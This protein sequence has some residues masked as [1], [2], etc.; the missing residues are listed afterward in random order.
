MAN[1]FSFFTFP[2]GKEKVLLSSLYLLLLFTF[3]MII[4]SCQKKNET[5]FKA[6]T[7]DK[8]NV[9]FAN[10]ITEND[11]FNILALEYVYNGGGVAAGDFNNDGLQDLYFTGNMVSNKLYLNKGDMEF[12]DVTDLAGVRG[13]GNWSSGVAV[14]DINN[15]G[16]LDLYVCSTV[17]SD[18]LRRTN[19]LF[20]NQGPNQDGVPT[21]TE[22]ARSYGIADAGYS[23]NAA[24][25]DFDLD[26]D[27]DLYVLTNQMSKHLPTSYKN[28]KIDGSALNNDRLYRNNGDNTFT[29]ITNEAGILIEGYGL[30]LAISDINQDGWPDVY[31]TNDFI[32]EDLLYINNGDGT[33]TN[34][35][36]DYMKHTSASAMGNDVVDINNDGLP[37]ILA[38]DMLPAPNMRK[39]TML[40][41]NNYATY[42]NNEKFNLQHQYIRNTF[43]LNNGTGPKGHPTFSEIGMLAGIHQTDWSWAPLVA[44]FDNDGL[45]DLIITNGFPR[46]VTDHDFIH[47]R[48]GP[49]GNIASIEMLVDLIPVV[50]IS[51][52]GFRNNGDLT[53]SDKTKEWGLNIPSFSNGAVYVDLDNDGDLEVVVNTIN[54]PALVYENK[55]YD[56]KNQDQQSHHLRIKLEGEKFN[57]SGFGTKVSIHYGQGKK[58]FYE[59]SPSRGYLSSVEAVG[60][61][62]LGSFGQIDSLQVFW[63][64]GSYQL[65]RNVSSN[66]QLTVKQSDAKERT[67]PFLGENSNTGKNKMLF[68]EVA[69]SYGIQ[70]R[71]QET[72]KIDFDIQRTLP[73]KYSQS[74]PG[75]A[76]GDVDGNGL[77]DFFVGGAAGKSAALFLQTSEGFSRADSSYLNLVQAKAAEDMGSIFFDADGDGD[78]DLYVVSGSYEFEQEAPELQDRLYLNN[79]QGLFTLDPTALPK[80][81]SSGAPVKAADFDQDGDLDLFVGGRIVSGKYPLPS[82]SYILRNQ[83]GQFMDVTAELCPELKRF[84][85]ISDALW[86]DFNNDGKI[87]LVI[88]AEWQ[89]L[90]FFK[91]VAGTLI[92]VTPSSGTAHLKGW[93]NSLSSGD[94]DGD[95]DIDYVAGNLGLNTHYKASEEQPLAVYAKDFDEDGRFDAVL[96]CYWKAED[97]QMKSYPMHTRDDLIVQML[98]T[99]RHFPKY[100]EYGGATIEQVLS[101]EDLEGALILKANHFATTYFENLGNGKFK[102]TPL[103]IQ[104]QFAPVFGMMSKDFDGDEKKDILLVGNNYG[105]EVFTG[106]HDASIGLFLKGDGKGGFK[107]K[108]VANSGFF[109][110]GDAKGMAFLYDKNGKALL[111]VS[112]NQDSLKLFTNAGLVPFSSNG[113]L[114]TLE[115]MDAWAEIHYQSGKKEK[116]EFYY[117]SSYL[118]Q[119][120][121]KLRLSA[122]VKGVTIYDFKGKSRKISF[123]Q[124]KELTGVSK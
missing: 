121:R 41:A 21:F 69:I 91:N 34:Q 88:A 22:S 38:M 20:I 100:K 55:L 42:T 61:F 48:S 95:G 31:V 104:A 70:Y 120:S 114:L 18:S 111:L 87:D 23:T 8:T 68:Q 45:R 49:A 103:P 119:S 65:L 25:F 13:K 74:G 27:L 105:S 10:T 73:H 110:E 32:T 77:D 37:D 97:G 52:Y 33:F 15:D 81:T 109:V 108:P 59:H 11:T 94:F 57:V 107:S 79:G 46:D 53:F 30:G 66:Q 83:G 40:N 29:N 123:A 112:Q 98:R 39:K 36:K 4:F 82:Q 6:L 122:E 102:A 56:G 92:N 5:L 96:S 58:Q 26:G 50:K 67:K 54:E 9:F 76:V 85:L 28:N 60:H 1:L 84:G 14:V 3:S 64:D 16:L 2:K 7:P 89:P 44:D 80:I 43:Q 63:P 78:L 71:H 47:Y 117:G 106:R 19:L 118:S 17:R 62:G 101:K 72:D 124:I 99:R 35:I 116:Q 86:T 75:L 115:P 24:F 90:S 12:E 93:W 113:H 51:N